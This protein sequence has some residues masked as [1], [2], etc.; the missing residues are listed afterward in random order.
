M[1]VTFTFLSFFLSIVLKAQLLSGFVLTEQGNEVPFASVFI[2]NSSIGT[3]SNGKGYY[4]IKYASIEDTIVFSA[5]GFSD[6]KIAV[7]DITSTQ[8]NINLTTEI[9]EVSTVEIDGENDFAKSIIKK[10]IKNRSKHFKSIS[11]FTADAYAKVSLEEENPFTPNTKD[12]LNFIEHYSVVH[13]QHPNNWKVE[14]MGVKDL[15]K[16]KED[17]GTFNI[18]LGGPNRRAP[19]GKPTNPNIFFSEISDGHFNFYRNTISIPK[20]GETPFISP[21]GNMAL[22]SYN[23]TYDGSFYE[24]KQLVHR[25]KVIPKRKK[26]ALF[27][28]VIYINDQIYN[29]AAVELSLP[30]S[31]LLFFKEFKVYQNYKETDSLFLLARQEFFYEVHRGKSVLHGSV[32]NEFKNY[33]VNIEHPKN[34]F[35]NNIRITRDSAY[36]RD[37][38]Y[39]NKVRTIPL[40]KAEKVFVNKADSINK[41]QKS[42]KYLRHLDSINNRISGLDIFLNGID[43]YNRERGVKWIIDPLLKQVKFAGVGGYRHALGGNYI[44]TFKN[45]NEVDFDGQVDYGFGNND[46]LANGKIK[47]TY[48]PKKFAQLRIGGGA[49]YQMLTYMQ[50]IATIFSRSNFVRND[51]IEVGH[52]HELF[53]GLFLDA[54]IKY[55]KRTSINHLQMAGWSDDLFGSDNE[56][57]NFDPYNEL[58]LRVIASY[59]PFQKFAIEPN[60]K[61]ILGSKWPTFKL[62]WEQGIPKVFDSKIHYQLLKLGVN[63]SIKWNVFGTG[64]YAFWAGKYLHATTVEYPN[65]TFFR[66]TDNYFFSHPIYTFQLL[67]NTLTAL[68]EFIEF[69]YIHHFNGMLIKKIPVLRKSKLE[70]VAG[71][72]FLGIKDQKFN[73]S[74]V[75]SGL[76]FPF[77]LWDTKF[78]IGAYYSVAYSNYSNL[79][80]MF[81]FGLNIYNPFTSTWAY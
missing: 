16:K 75:Y 60:K 18:R 62:H 25:I 63:Q 48:L 26:D 53:N 24:N 65:M 22:L 36:S 6:K 68:D 64:K 57:R 72:G 33:N 13:F 49:K 67:G 8:L 23:Y 7:R 69:H 44:K 37:S 4:Q 59:T 73:H 54:K 50:N 40:K 79:N 38:S 61:I 77:K 35:S 41:Y 51:Y 28:G 47:F 56:P 11:S 2:Q 27:S 30:S 1:K 76:E 71:G 15:S 29:L 34:T 45:D 12:K 58:N 70:T 78:K 81:K 46:L 32:Y 17:K 14:K 43:H 52:Y 39:W 9:N 42:P 31:C 10:V 55:M 3:F 5:I 19:K 20:L 80:N 66:G 74:E 21:I